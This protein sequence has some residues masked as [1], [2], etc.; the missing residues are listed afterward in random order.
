[1]A[2][3]DAAGDSGYW[4]AFDVGGT[5]IDILSF[6][7]RSG[8]IHSTKHR[9]S[10]HAAAE[11]IRTAIVEHLEAIRAA[12]KDIAQLA[13]GTTLVTNLLVEHAG[14]KVGVIT[15][16]GFRDVLEIGRMRRPSLY[17]LSLDKPPP[18]AARAWQARGDRAHR[19][20]W[21]S[22]GQRSPRMR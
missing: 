16:R 13:H 3:D 21:A 2:S 11:S 1:M 15:T 6:D 18:L 10:R 7:R 17:D 8:R 19:L 20:Q 9:S 4:L 12:P 14:A 5:F 22:H